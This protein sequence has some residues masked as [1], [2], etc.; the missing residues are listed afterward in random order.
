M[1]LQT[2]LWHELINQK[3]ILILCTIANELHKI[4]MVKLTQIVNFCLQGL[5]EWKSG[6]H[7][8]LK[9]EKTKAKEE[10]EIKLVNWST[11]KPFLVA[12]KAFCR[13]SFDSY[14][15][16]SSRLGRSQSVFIKP[17]FENASESSLSEKS[18]R[19]EVFGGS[20]KIRIAKSL[21]IARN[22]CI[23]IEIAGNWCTSLWTT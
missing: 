7:M 9:K 15:Y 11:Y 8:K 6:S 18:L 22:R 12:L 14:N 20:F 4:F 21:E 10:E 19:P 16:S 5:S 23:N 1:I 17:T 3:P 2:S 13:K